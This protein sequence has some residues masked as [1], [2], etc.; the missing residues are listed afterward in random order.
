MSVHI[1]GIRHH[2]PGCAR[3]LMQALETLRPD[4]VLIEG[5]PDAEELLPLAKDPDLRPPVAMLLYPPE[6]PGHAVFYP[7][8]EFS[9]EWRA[10]R[11]GLSQNIPVRFMDLP[12]AMQLV[13][14]EEPSTKDA[15]EQAEGSSEQTTI[16]EIVEESLQ[17]DPLGE[18]A[19]AAGYEDTETWW[20]YQIERR[21]DATGL[22][23]GILEAMAELRKNAK[24]RLRWEAEREAFM[25]QTIRQAIKE[26]HERIAVVCGAWHAPALVELGDAGADA[27]LLKGLP[28]R[29]VAA[30]WV[31]WSYGN[32]ARRSGYGAGVTCPGWYHLLF[33]VH[34]RAGSRWIAQAARQLRREGLEAS[35]ANVIE[36]IRLAEALAA[37]REQPLPALAELNEAILAVLCGGEPL[38]YEVIREKLEIGDRLGHVPASVPVVPLQRDL[39]ARQ[40]KLRLKPSPALKKLDLD[41][42]QETDRGRSRL[43]HQL[44]LLEIPWGQ[45]IDLRSKTSTFH[46]LWQL[47]WKPELALELIRAS[48]HGHTV[49]E[50]ASTVTRSRA[51]AA[52]KLDELTSLMLAALLADLPDAMIEVLQL[53]QNKAAQTS[54]VQALMHA[55]PPLAQVARY[56]DVRGTAQQEVM[57]ILHGLLE[58]ILV[59]LPA[60]CASLDHEAS[61]QMTQA[62]AHVQECLDLL[63]LQEQKSAW[64]AVLRRLTEDA[65]LHGRIRGWCC[66]CLLEAQ[67]LT[68]EELHRQARIALSPTLPQAQAA[69]WIEGLLSGS[70]PRL[71]QEDALWLALDGWVRDLSAE[72]FVELLPLLRRA[73]THFQPPERRAVGEKIESLAQ[74]GK[75][76]ARATLINDDLHADR[77]ALVVPIL[78]Q[79]LGMPVEQL[80]ERE[81]A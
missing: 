42:R 75:T 28:R 56:G 11:Y 70:V 60:A 16:R 80:F 31:P 18:L 8:A 49:V 78:S 7:F 41:L 35:S 34:V 52:A 43:L 29:K 26:K 37:L 51:K 13:E 48:Q 1:F 44:T 64:I 32:L 25:R 23:Q 36:A 79:V 74:S 12:Q 39:E 58:R 10:L 54:E 38:R 9:P 6:E 57:P 65:S 14:C 61:I 17:D 53:L 71:L 40:K 21:Q 4:I 63:S 3:A 55:L 66:R 47:E 5:P 72:A 73:C 19:R 46:E 22:F 62:M 24:P 59:G 50:A 81:L 33:D 15:S 27:A 45:R 20:E 2:G 77:A 76:R 30:A 68:S 69:A 67:A